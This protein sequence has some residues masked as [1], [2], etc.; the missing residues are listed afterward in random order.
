M[1]IY[2]GGR[3]GRV[4]RERAVIGGFCTRG[5]VV[6]GRCV[7]LAACCDS[8]VYCHRSD[9]LVAVGAFCDNEIMSY[10]CVIL[11]S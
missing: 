5:G 3:R 8:V 6:W 10:D 11:L 4:S 1:L 9:Q 2:I 7:Q